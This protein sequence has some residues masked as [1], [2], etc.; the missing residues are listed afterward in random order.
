MYKCI[1]LSYFLLVA[2]GCTPDQASGPGEVRWDRETCTRC[3]M[4]VGDRSFAAQVRAAPSGEKSRL[5]K[6]DDIGCAVI[7]LDTQSWKNDT[8]TEIWVADHRNG[9]W[10]DARKAHFVT[11]KL[12]PMNYGLAAQAEEAEGALDFSQ[13]IEHIR[14]AENEQHRHGGHNPVINQ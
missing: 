13:A 4:A 5:Y 9:K 3:S 11:G 8:G 2:A 7:W 1:L 10:L 14:M 6:F 12:S